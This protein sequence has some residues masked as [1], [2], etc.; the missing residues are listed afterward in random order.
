MFLDIGPITRHTVAI[1]V[2]YHKAIMSAVV[3]TLL[4]PCSVITEALGAL[5]FTLYIIIF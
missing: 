4:L 5:H 2:R 1:Y 3:M